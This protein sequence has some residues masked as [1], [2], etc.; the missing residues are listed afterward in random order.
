MFLNIPY[1]DSHCHLYEYSIDNIKEY[2]K[3]LIIAAV[4]DDLESSIETLNLASK[5]NNIVPC[6]GVHPWEVG[7]TPREHVRKIISLIGKHGIKCLG[8]IGLDKKFVPETIDRQREFFTEFLQAAQEYELVVNIHAVNTWNEVL[9]L[10]RKYDI[11]KAVFHWYTG[12]VE[13]IDEI[14]YSGY[15]ISINPAFTIQDKHRRIVDYIDLEFLLT[16]SDGPYNYRGLKLNPLMVKE[17]VEYV[18]KVKKLSIGNVKKIIYDNFRK[19][20]TV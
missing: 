4:S 1:V 6:V 9:E 3:I 11:E 16:E 17:T 8:E 7:N 13:L 2:L 5:F 19:L 10:L 15:F 20:F 18:S 14:T 12:P